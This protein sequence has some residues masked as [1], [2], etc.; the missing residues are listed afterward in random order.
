[1]QNLKIVIEHLN[2]TYILQLIMP[3]SVVFRY[4]LLLPF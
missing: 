4:A 2:K 1:M 3:T